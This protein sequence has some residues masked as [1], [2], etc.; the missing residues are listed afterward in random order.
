LVA[1]ALAIAALVGSRRLDTVVTEACASAC[2]L[3]F[4]RGHRRSL[5]PRGRLGF[6][7]P[8]EVGFL[9]GTHAVDARSERNA[10]LRAGLEADFVARALTP[11]P[12]EMWY[13]DVSRLRRVGAV[14]ELGFDPAMN[15]STRKPRRRIAWSGGAATR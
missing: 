6:H 2:T 12:G 8:Y 10:Y 1:E 11:G 3:I 13:P 14:T 7:G 4:V 5:G 9:Q 15:A